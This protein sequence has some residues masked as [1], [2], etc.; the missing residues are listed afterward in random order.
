M[1][2]MY[3]TTEWKTSCCNAKTK[4]YQAHDYPYDS[5]K[6]CTKCG[7]TFSELQIHR[8]QHLIEKEK[9]N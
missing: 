4:P 7:L 5:G 3:D 9:D 8:G 1:D 2:G 6:E